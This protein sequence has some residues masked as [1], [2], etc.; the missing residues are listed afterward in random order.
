[1]TEGMRQETP[2]LAVSSGF[3][4]VMSLVCDALDAPQRGATAFQIHG[5]NPMALVQECTRRLRLLDVMPEVLARLRG[6][7]AAGNLSRPRRQKAAGSD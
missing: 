4:T 3:R 2:L 7:M 6:G 5:L 1:M